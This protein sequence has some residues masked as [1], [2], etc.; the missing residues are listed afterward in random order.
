MK[1]LKFK[2][3][4]QQMMVSI[5]TLIVLICLGLTLVSITFSR[6]SIINTVNKTLPEISEQAA[7]TVKSGITEK[8]KVLDL[9]ATHPILYDEKATLDQ[10]LAFLD[11]ERK[12]SGHLSMTLVDTKGNAINLERNTFNIAEQNNYKKAL[13][14]ISNVCNPVISKNDGSLIVMYSVPIK[15]GDAIV[16]VINAVRSS[17]E[18]STYTNSIKLGNTAKAY[19]LNNEGTIIADQNKD[20]II[21]Q[22]NHIKNLSKDSSLEGLVTIEKN[23]INGSKGSGQYKLNGKS[24]F[25]GYAPVKDTGWSLAIPVDSNEILA[26]LSVLTKGIIGVSILFLVVGALLAY[27]VASNI[28]KPINSSI[29]E[30]TLIADGDLTSDIPSDLLTRKDEIG[31]MVKAINT[32]KYS[33]LSIL[34]DI[35]DS[36]TYINNQTENLYSI[37]KNFIISSEGI[38]VATN[39][40]ARCNIEQA[41]ALTD[42]SSIVDSFSAK[43]D[44]VVK[45]IS[46]VDSS[47]VDIKN[48]A[49]NSNVDMDNVVL[50]VKEL[51][52]S[53]SNLIS[54]TK[55]VEINV[56][57]INEITNL[58]NNISEQTNLLAL[59]AAIES[60]RAGESGRGFSVVADEIKKL[61]QQSLDSSVN[62]SKIISEISSDTELMVKT[63]E[64]VNV[65]ISKQESSISTAIDSFNAITEAVQS[66][67]PKMDL[68]NES[69]KSLQTNKEVILEKVDEAAAT[70]QTVS[71]S[72]QEIAAS[73]E[74]MGKGVKN[75]ATS[76][77]QLTE[78]S[79][80][81][82]DNVNKFKM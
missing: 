38:N 33:I 71:A 40:V 45:L 54:K 74:E 51:N 14:G 57:K 39:D 13:E 3:L 75:I 19:M 16:G 66:I 78:M 18:L 50:S 25:I 65:E 27:F 17:D 29:N 49:D 79:Q 22:T 34:N 44:E 32:M 24:H 6:Q 72:S 80:S 15:K 70:S 36:S 62:I 4:K 64:T 42:I 23:M 43:L 77:N 59:N 28:S 47:T 68:A 11:T 8:L 55:N 60:A 2:S 61:A 21:N 69:T 53:F 41:S 37:S 7:A 52:K 46:E 26:E 67:T 73:T 5:V 10:K 76:L 1:F 81:L 20:I 30:L 56:R 9:L 35:K 63:T 58:I 48:M 82:M 31:T 12:R